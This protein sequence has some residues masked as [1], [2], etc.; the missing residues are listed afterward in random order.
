MFFILAISVFFIY[1]SVYFSIYRKKVYPKPDG[2]VYNFL[3][4]F[5]PVILIK[6][7]LVFVIFFS[8]ELFTLFSR[9]TN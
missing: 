2:L 8:W 5:N 1:F 7:S 6:S 4:L 9:L 3:E